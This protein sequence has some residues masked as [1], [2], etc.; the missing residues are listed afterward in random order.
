V[1][2]FTIHQHTAFVTVAIFTEYVRRMSFSLTQPTNLICNFMILVRGA[3]AL[4]TISSYTVSF[5]G[6]TSA[7]M[8]ECY[9]VPF[10]SSRMSW[11]DPM[12]FFDLQST[13]TSTSKTQVYGR[14]VPRAAPPSP[15]L[16]ALRPLVQPRELFLDE[17][18]GSALPL[19]ED[20]SAVS[21]S[22]GVIAW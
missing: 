12:E 22:R 7:C 11:Q 14:R 13:P 15:P 10:S 19:Q 21:W 2:N 9:N 16:P 4:R 6:K 1:E 17:R 5:G 8:Q 20:M 18:A 3:R